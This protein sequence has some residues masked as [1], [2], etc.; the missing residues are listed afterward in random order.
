MTAAPAPVTTPAAAP[1]PVTGIPALAPER[2]FAFFAERLGCQADPADV[3]YALRDDR[4]DFTI[5]DV[6]I[7]GAHR[8]THLP[9]AVSLPLAEITAERVAELPRACWWSTAGARPATA[10]PRAR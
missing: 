6:R 5:V 3:W 2:A 8:R 7:E 10:P 1:S 9:G 4:A